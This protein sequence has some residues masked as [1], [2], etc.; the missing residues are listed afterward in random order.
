MRVASVEMASLR[1]T[2]WGTGIAQAPQQSERVLSVWQEA[3]KQLPRV[4]ESVS[5]QQEL[6]EFGD[7]LFLQNKKRYTIPGKTQ[8]KIFR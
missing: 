5:T 2:A 4:G 3:I 7:K 8:L 1:Y 6:L